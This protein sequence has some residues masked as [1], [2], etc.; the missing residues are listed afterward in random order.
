MCG[1][2]GAGEWSVL[3]SSVPAEKLSSTLHP[4][5]GQVPAR[6]EAVLTY[7]DPGRLVTG[8]RHHRRTSPISTSAATPTCA[9]VEA[10]E[11]FL[12]TLGAGAIVISGDLSQRARHGEFQAAHV[13]VAAHARRMRRRW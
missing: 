6:G 12:P 1:K 9:Q 10:L 13:F 11:K 8:R 2:S 7:R 5:P 3:S 4:L